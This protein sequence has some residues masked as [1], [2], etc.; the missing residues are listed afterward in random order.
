MI[1]I[2][3]ACII[4]ILQTCAEHLRVDVKTSPFP[5]RMQSNLPRIQ[6]VR[7]LVR[8]N[9][10]RAGGI[11]RAKRTLISNMTTGCQ[12]RHCSCSLHWYF[13]SLWF[14]TVSTSYSPVVG[15]V[16]L[17]SSKAK[18]KTYLFPRSSWSKLSAGPQ[19]RAEHHYSCK[20]SSTQAPTWTITC[21]LCRNTEPFL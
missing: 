15:Y 21:A 11:E 12:H 20:L 3:Y 17:F 1:I 7:T 19:L 5:G 13:V 4:L 8:Q 2:T 14:L 18:R 9:R 6:P 16:K 10:N